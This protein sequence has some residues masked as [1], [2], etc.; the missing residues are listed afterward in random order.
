MDGEINSFIKVWLFTITS[1]CYCYYITGRIPPGKY[2][3]LSLLPIFCLFLSL[4]FNLSS[5][6]LGAP[7][8]LYL[9][10]LGNFKL[11]LFSFGLP[12]LSSSTGAPI[13]FLHFI[14][15]ASLPIKITQTR[16]K[17]PDKSAL[18]A[19][20]V[21]L[22]AVIIQI[23]DYRETL[24]PN[25]VLALYCCHLYLGVAIFLAMGASLARAFLGV[26]LEPQ[27]NKPYLASSLQ[28]F[29]GRRWNL[30]V[31]SILR[32]T[33]YDPIRRISSP[34]LGARWAHLPA[35]VAAFFVSGIMHEL[36]Y[37]YFTHVPPT[38]EVTS[39]FVLH[40]VC[41]AAEVVAKKTLTDNCRLPRAV[42]G[43]LTIGFVALTG[44][45]LFFPQITRNGLDEKAIKEYSILVNFI[46]D[47][48]LLSH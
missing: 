18:F 34:A 36:L 26:E 31:T 46:K 35:I 33:V 38:W 45:W 47:K 22:L 13:P 4:P 23:Y 15:T 2:R 39:F 48:L 19:V 30:M 21:V 16:L 24:H 29:W 44:R 32:P 43:P 5:F 28:D 37:F 7:T 11:I 9:V 17:S 40:G 20:K 1:L 3:F 12:P 10:W 14:L 25:V 8:A 42:S 27:F 41:T 6:H